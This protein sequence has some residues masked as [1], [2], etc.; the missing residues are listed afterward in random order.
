MSLTPNDTM[1]TDLLQA[2][3]VLSDD[4]ETEV[5]ARLPEGWQEQAETRKA[6]VRS[7]KLRSAGDLLR[8]LLAYVLCARSFRH[9][10]MWSVMLGLADVSEAD[11]RKRLRQAG[12]WLSWLVRER[13]AVTACLTPWL[14]RAGWKRI[15]LMDAT[16]L[17]VPG[18]GRLTWR[19]HT[20]FDLLAGRLT[21]L[22][23]TDTHV[24]ENIR[25]LDVQ[26]GDLVITDRANGFRD[27]IAFVLSR[28]ADAI[29]R[30][31]PQSLPLEE[32]DGTVI[33][34]A[35]W[36][37]DRR[38]PAGRRVSR[39]VWITCEEQRFEIRLVALRLT[40]AQR[41]KA[42]KRQRAKAKNDKRVIQEDTL[43]YAGW[44]LL[45]TT[46]PEDQWS[47]AQVLA[48]YRSRWHIELLFKRMKQILGKQQVRCR[49][50]LSARANIAVFLLC[51]SLQ[52]EEASLVRLALQGASEA[53]LIPAS[54][55]EA[56]VVDVSEPATGPLSF[57]QL[58]VICLDQL[59]QVVHGV[60]SPERFRASI[61]RCR[62]FLQGSHRQRTHWYSTQFQ[63]FADPF[64]VEGSP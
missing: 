12:D 36:L 8:G 52:E 46:L 44:L 27:R 56:L 1:N 25:L 5:L 31:T 22:H 15:L 6:F 19:L 16:H 26:A 21:D 62:R 10:G 40:E 32:K 9:L 57:W 13:L 33:N 64:R 43:Y 20:A 24:A 49:N 7:R 48:L 34:L 58:T 45:V 47:P 37:Q 35:A 42:Q 3:T 18:A 38:A 51:W 41:A 59:R 54:D 14:V 4:W 63:Q 28:H 61:G 39:R 2:E 11:W 30:F 23:V 29:F 53:L 60:V 17:T 55:A 50:A